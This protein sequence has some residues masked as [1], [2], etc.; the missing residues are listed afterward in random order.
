MKYLIDFKNKTSGADIKSYLSNNNCTVIKEWD[1]FEK[2]FLVETNI[3]PPAN[4]IIERISEE[5]SVAISPLDTI[6]INSYYGTHENPALNLTVNVNDDKDWWKNYCY[7][8]PEFNESTITINRLGQGINVYVM[9]SGIESNH[10][11]FLTRKVKLLHSVTGDFVDKHGHGTAIASVIIGETCGITDCTL[12]VVK[13]FDPDHITLEHELLDAIDAIITDHIDGR[14]SVLNCSWTIPKNEW[15][16]HKLRVLEDAGVFVVAAAGNNGSSIEDV[17]PASM[18]DVITVG[19]YNQNLTPCDFSNYTGNSIISVTGNAVNHGELD[20]WAPGEKI[21]AAG[22]NG[23]YGFVAGTSIATAITS[24]CLASNHTWSIDTDAKRLKHVPYGKC[25]TNTPGSPASVFMRPNL[26]DFADEKYSNSVNVVATLYDKS[27]GVNASTPTRDEFNCTIRTGSKKHIGRV[28]NNLLTKSIEFI[29]PLPENFEIMIDGQLYGAP[30]KEQGPSSAELYQ[31]YTSKFIRTNMD[32]TNETVTINIYVYGENMDP[33]SLPSNDPVAITLQ[34]TDC[35][36]DPFSMPGYCILS[37]NPD[38]CNDTCPQAGT[39]C[40]Q[41]QKLTYYCYCDYYGGGGGSCC[42]KADTP[43]TMSDGSTK[44]IE[45]IMVGDKILSY[46]IFTNNT[47]ENEVSKVIDRKFR[48]MYILTLSNE[49]TVTVSIDHPFYVVG[50]GYASLDPNATAKG[51]EGYEKLGKINWLKKGDT[52][53][54]TDK[55]TATILSI[56]PAYHDDKVY[57]L[58]NKDKSHPNYFANGILVY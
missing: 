4:S 29:K 42:F 22:L 45:D 6:E 14:I 32:D 49:K 16:E 33:K 15:V 54:M 12:K 57:T 25:S 3:A 30:T 46:N 53:L 8:T 9:D 7:I 37:P 26:L 43:I 51:N 55:S 19:A 47:F 50:S 13:I 31:T 11:E 52:L 58:A 28:Y 44:L 39:C 34:T 36:F 23:T 48:D 18:M 38:D 35:Y 21:Y 56:E 10:P 2:I 41:Q 20:G 24:A 1:N 40:D 27:K 5:N 17:T